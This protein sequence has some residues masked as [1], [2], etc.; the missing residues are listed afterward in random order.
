MSSLWRL[1]WRLDCE[2]CGRQMAIVDEDETFGVPGVGP[3]KPTFPSPPQVPEGMEREVE[4]PAEMATYLVC[5]EDCRKVIDH[6]P[7]Q[8]E[9]E[10]GCDCQSPNGVGIKGISNYC[11]VHNENPMERPR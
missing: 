9:V 10:A 3:Y 4:D 2:R 1:V 5:C 11:P 8:E 6:G 7:T